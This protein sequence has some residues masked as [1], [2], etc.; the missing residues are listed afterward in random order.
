MEDSN[1]CP[2]PYVG[3]DCKD[4][5]ANAQ[6]SYFLFHLIYVSCVVLLTIFTSF[7][8]IRLF[9]LKKQIFPLDAQQSIFLLMC[10]V[11]VTFVIRCVGSRYVQLF[12]TSFLP[13]V[14]LRSLLMAWSSPFDIH[15]NS[16]RRRHLCL[17]LV[18][19]RGHILLD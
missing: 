14:C 18:F 13:Q 10:L 9:R 12:F 6:Q 1:E 3:V 17:V 5:V 19:F 15:D 7:Q 11:D 4:T 8:A 2:Y 16:L